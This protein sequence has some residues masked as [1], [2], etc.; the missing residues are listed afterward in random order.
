MK[1]Y[2]YHFTP[3]KGWCNDPN[4][5]IY[6]NGKYHL[7][8]QHYPDDTV[9]GPMHWGHA[10]SDNLIDWEHKRIAIEPD[11]L[12][13]IFSGSCIYDESFMGKGALIA[14]YTSHNP[15]T[16]EQ[17]QC[18][19]YSFDFE[20]FEKYEGNPIIANRKDAA[21]YMPDFRDPKVFKNPLKGGYTMAL[22]AGTV[23]KFYH[24]MD[25]IK[26]DYTGEFDPEAKGFGGICECPDCFYIENDNSNGIWILSLSSILPDDKIG[27][28]LKEGQ[29]SYNRVMQY[30]VGQFDGNTFTRTEELQDRRAA[31]IGKMFGA[32]ISEKNPLIMDYGLDNYAMVTFTDAPEKSP[33]MIGWGECW[34][35]V[36]K[37]PLNTGGEIYAQNEDA[38]GIEN[39]H[40]DR[41]SRG[42]MTL[43]RTLHL[44]ETPKG[45]RLAFSISV[46][47]PHE[48]FQLA[49]GQSMTLYGENNKPLVITLADKKIW[50]LRKPSDVTDKHNSFCA[51]RVYDGICEFEVYRD[52]NYFEIFAEKGLCPFSVVV[53]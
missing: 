44:V 32:D 41:I 5:T 31:V 2:T 42:K 27:N 4:G 12:G 37:T 19:A 53:Y 24:S 34:E 35:Y 46:S 26:W 16:G 45:K 21:D 20:H 11:E 25:L 51:D 43:P 47:I 38:E 50:V 22:A 49:D 48:S 14:F 15:D 1:N 7:F 52:G 30:F 40:K 39:K 29:Y 6:V 17:Q 23:I 13:Y 9:W 28:N 3:E 33:V 36:N 18:M 10:V 8:Y